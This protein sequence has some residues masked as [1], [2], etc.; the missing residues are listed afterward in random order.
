MYNVSH[1]EGGGGGRG[2]GGVGGVEG[3]GGGRCQRDLDFMCRPFQLQQTLFSSLCNR[4]LFRT[5]IV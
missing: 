4:E 5:K 3:G 2:G 1:G